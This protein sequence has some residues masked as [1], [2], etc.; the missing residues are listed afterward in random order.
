MTNI[1]VTGATGNIGRLTLQH[2]LKRLPASNLV[3]LVRDPAKAAALAAEGIEIRQGDYL[4]YDGL[5]RAFEG[6]EKVM[7]VSAT[8]FTDRNSQHENVINA[9]REARV[10]HIVFMPIIRKPGSAFVLPQ[11]TEEDLF[12]E[13]RLKSSGLTFTFV[14]HPPFLDNIEFYVRGNALETGVHTPAGA[15]KAA[16]ACRDDLAEAHAVVLS[17]S[18]HENKAYSLYGDPAVSFEDVAQILSEISGKP[19]PY[20]V[21]SDQ[22]YIAQL[23]AA[24]LPEPAA[25]FVL[26]WVHGVTAGEWDGQTA[27]LETLLGRKPVSAAEYLRASFAAR[28]VKAPFEKEDAANA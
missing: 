10:K 7:L 12:V 22:D 25:G 23:M 2:L 1:L 17:E 21:V 11:V 16:Y 19:V 24:G 8:A 27:D 6:I 20:N 18:G 5:V 3:G 14:R 9:A 4:D 13:E 15:G 26:A 28:L